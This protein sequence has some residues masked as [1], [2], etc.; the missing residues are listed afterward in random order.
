MLFLVRV[1]ATSK[2]IPKEVPYL[3]VGGGTASFAAF[4]AIK[5]N[6]PKAKVCNFK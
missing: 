5:S 6:N 1:P 2:D 4:R 3:L